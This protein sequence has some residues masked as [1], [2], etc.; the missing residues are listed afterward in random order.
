MEPPSYQEATLHP[1]AL[2]TQGLNTSPPPSYYAS[3]SSPPTPPPTY[4]EAV[5]I[6]QDPFPVLSLPS[7]PTSG[8]STL[9]N[10]GDII[11]PRTQVGA[12]QTVPIALSNLTRKPG[13]VRC[14][15]CHQTVTTKVTY[16]PSKDAWGL[17]ILLAVLGLF[18]G[19]CLIPLIVHGLQDANHSC[20]QCGK[21]VFT[22]TEPNNQESSR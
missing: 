15:H 17:C 2:N 12:T 8:S 16:Q 13:L 19:F 6:Q 4:G 9:Q 20:P 3:L 14:P 5:T 18:C 1:P 10:T 7:V 21:H 22:Y 11:H